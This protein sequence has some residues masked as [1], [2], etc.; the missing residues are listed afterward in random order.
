MEIITPLLIIAVL[1]ILNGVFVAAE[2]AI[3]AVPKTRMANLSNQGSKIAGS[4]LKILDDPRLQN[5]F[6]ATAQVG[7]TIVSLGLGM[8]GEHTIAGWILLAFEEFHIPEAAAHT[9]ATILSVGAL[10]YVHVVLGEMIPKSLALQSAEPTI[11][12]LHP[13]MVT[14]EKI[15]L[16]FVIALNWMG[17]TFI[18]LLG[19]TPPESGSRLF[20]SDE[21]E[22]IVE[23][24]FEGGLIGPSDQLFIENILDLESRTAEQAMTPRNKLVTIACDSS[25]DEVLQII[26]ESTKT[27]YPVYDDTTDNIT[28]ILHIKDLARALINND[29]AEPFNLTDILRPTI[30]I[31]ESLPLDETLIKFRKD[32]IQIG[33]VMDEFGGTAGVITLEDLVEEVVGEIQDE[34]D[35]EQLPI[36]ELSMNRIKVRGD[37]I[38]EELN[39]HYDLNW[40]HEEANTIGGFTVAQLGNIPEDGEVIEYRGVKIEV[41]EV[42]DHAIINLIL[43]LPAPPPPENPGH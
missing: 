11:F 3:V 20:T 12:F 7:I 15:F 17:N 21:L 32:N 36:Q 33:I 41:L 6:I 16:P 43:H 10:T 9:A 39:Q 34:F 37:V 27:R 5:R 13:I 18:E 26:C 8:Y 31:P 1:V 38:L 24:S 14:L 42:K 35:E 40:S 29:Q 4:V 28:G 22:Y 19:I 25:R 2:F 23:E 30:F